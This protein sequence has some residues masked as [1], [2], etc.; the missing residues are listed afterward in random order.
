MNDYIENLQKEYDL[1][2]QLHQC[3]K[4]KYTDVI[5]E[6]V[7]TCFHIPPSFVSPWPY[8]LKLCN[9]CNSLSEYNEQLNQCPYCEAAYETNAPTFTYAHWRPI[10]GNR[11]VKKWGPPL[12][13]KWTKENIGYWDVDRSNVEVDFPQ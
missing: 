13:N 8:I 9:H 6:L 10:T 12:K 2:E 3:K 4:E 5:M 1:L 11:L 7:K